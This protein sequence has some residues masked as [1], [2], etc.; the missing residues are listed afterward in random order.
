M[1]PACGKHEILSHSR[2]NTRPHGA[3]FGPMQL[4]L[5]ALLARSDGQRI[6]SM[7]CEVPLAQRFT[8]P[9]SLYDIPHQSISLVTQGFL[10]HAKRELKTCPTSFPSYILQFRLPTSVASLSRACYREASALVLHPVRRLQS[11]HCTSER[12]SHRRA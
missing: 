6:S 3:D 9:D 2:E 12:S 7:M 8:E 11:L 4:V 1:G 10:Q 5:D